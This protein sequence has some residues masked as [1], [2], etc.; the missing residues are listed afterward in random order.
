MLIK[1]SGNGSS[2]CDRSGLICAAAA[3]L[4]GQVSLMC[5]GAIPRKC[6]AVVQYWCRHVSACVYLLCCSEQAPKL[7]NWFKAL[8][9]CTELHAAMLHLQVESNFIVFV[10]LGNEFIQGLQGFTCSVLQNK[11]AVMLDV[12]AQLC[13]K[14]DLQMLKVCPWQIL[15]RWHQ[16]FRL[17]VPP[18]L[19][20]LLLCQEYMI[21]RFQP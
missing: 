3:R 7:C 17:E 5:I 11:G 21:T 18:F 12:I 6:I 13:L 15:H 1:L 14:S 16:G 4:P 20:Y 8:H 9:H 19:T 10:L 2:N